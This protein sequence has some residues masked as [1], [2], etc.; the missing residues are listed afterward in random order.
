MLFVISFFIISSFSFSNENIDKAELMFVNGDYLDAKVLYE[1]FNDSSPKSNYIG[2]QI[3]YELDDLSN[4]GKLLYMLYNSDQDKYDSEYNNFKDFYDQLT[5]VNITIDQGY[6]D[7]AILEYEKLLTSYPSNSNIF[8]KIGVCYKKKKEYDLAVN[9]FTKAKNIK[10]YVVRYNDEVRNIAK[11]QAKLGQDEF[12]RQDYQA[13]LN[14]YEKSISF[15]STYSTPMF[16]I[17]NVYYKIKDYDKAIEYYKKG[18]NFADLSPHKYR[19]LYQLG[20]FFTKVNNNKKAIEAF[21]ATLELKPD[22]TKAMF[23]KAKISRSI[24]DIDTAK[25]ILLQSIDIDPSY[26]KAFEELMDIEIESE[27]YDAAISHGERCLDFNPKSSTVKYRFAKLYNI[28]EK[29]SDAKKYA[30]EAIAGNRKYAAA[31]Y[32]LGFAEMNLCNKVA[33]KDAF[34][35]SKSDRN[36]RKEASAMLKQLDQRISENCN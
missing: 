5:S 30:K 20:V 36:F 1:Q 21:D 29:Y 7:D 16:G 33:A 11:G 14:Y 19:R 31:L 3:Y 26:E 32:E 18:I 2:F 28:T 4:A 12:K 15:D 17:G 35:K 25:M 6:Y 23:E 34:N 22:Y 8:Y 10:P 13:A 24:G 9:Y 27:N